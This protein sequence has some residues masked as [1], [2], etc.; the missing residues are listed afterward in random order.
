MPPETPP[1]AAP[2]LARIG[3][4]DA[5]F[6]AADAW[7]SWMVSAANEREALVTALKRDHGVTVAHKWRART[8]TG[9]RTC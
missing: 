2:M 6:D 7:G 8:K 5:L 4:I 9:G 3:K 1:A